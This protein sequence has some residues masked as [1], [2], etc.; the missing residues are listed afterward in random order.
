MEPSTHGSPSFFD[1]YAYAITAAGE[2]AFKGHLAAL[3]H[4]I[5]FTK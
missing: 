3:E 4:M 1:R 5:K 2:K